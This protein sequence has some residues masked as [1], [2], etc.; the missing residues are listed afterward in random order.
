MGLVQ[1]KK[2]GQYPISV[3][4]STKAK[5]IQEIQIFKNVVFYTDLTK[6][7]QLRGLDSL[8]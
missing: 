4:V 8:G 1:N 7:N 2:L 6:Q 5:H 3:Q